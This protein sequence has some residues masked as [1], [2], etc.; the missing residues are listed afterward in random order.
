MVARPAAGYTSLAT[1]GLPGGAAGRL[2]GGMDALLFVV[3]MVAAL[4]VAAVV[5]GR[6][7]R[8]PSPD[9]PTRPQPG[10]DAID[11]RDPRDRPSGPGASFD[12]PHSSEL[13]P[14]EVG[15]DER[16]GSDAARSPSPPADDSGPRQ[17]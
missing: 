9:N 10:E 4:A 13:Q 11:A 6:T 5:I 2:G 15:G 14:G 3:I 16:E 1:A 7:Q 8:A 12:A 17:E